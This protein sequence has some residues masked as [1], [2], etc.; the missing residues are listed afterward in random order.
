MSYRIIPIPIVIIFFII[1]IPQLENIE[2]YL[3]SGKLVV[4]DPKVPRKST[5]MMKMMMIGGGT[6]NMVWIWRL[7]TIC[8][9]GELLRI[10]ILSFILADIMSG[11]YHWF[12]DSYRTKY[13]IVNK[14]LFENFQLHHEVPYLITK[15]DWIYVSWELGAIAIFGNLVGYI[16][17]GISERPSENWMI[18]HTLWLFGI[19][20]NHVHRCAHMRC[21]IPWPLQNS[22]HHA[23]HHQRPELRCYCILSVLN[24]GWIDYLNIWAIAEWIIYYIFGAVSFRM[25]VEDPVRFQKASNF[26]IDEVTRGREE[27]EQSTY[28]Q[29]KYSDNKTNSLYS[30]ITNIFKYIVTI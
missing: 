17:G 25:A 2:S 9:I 15:H 22:K 16:Y 3:I 19:W 27:I 24:N 4:K 28:K 29:M 6:L 13:E 10:L 20:I 1:I 30:K 21:Y 18:W 23:I 7:L 11:I 14:A 26:S 12:Q 5:P 8:E